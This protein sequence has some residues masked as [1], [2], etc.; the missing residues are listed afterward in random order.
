MSV[1]QRQCRVSYK[2]DAASEAFSLTRKSS[3]RAGGSSA[4][5]SALPRAASP[6]VEAARAESE[7]VRQPLLE[8]GT[9]VRPAHPLT[10]PLEYPCGGKPGAGYE[11]TI[12]I[13][14]VG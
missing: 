1:A 9:P 3:A 6:S 14:N 5:A 13:S 10:L 8:E 4:A 7:S 12:A 2:D 11:L